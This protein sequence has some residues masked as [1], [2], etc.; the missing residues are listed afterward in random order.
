MACEIRGDSNTTV[1]ALTTS[2]PC[3]HTQKGNT[4]YRNHPVPGPARWHIGLPPSLTSLSVL[5]TTNFDFYQMK[6]I[7]Y[8]GE[9]SL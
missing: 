1:D 8:W 7:C 3:S 5:A 9:V 2:R 4:F 6:I